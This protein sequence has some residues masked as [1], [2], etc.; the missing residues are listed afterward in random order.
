MKKTTIF[1]IFYCC[2]C[3]IFCSVFALYSYELSEVGKVAAQSVKMRVCLDAGHGGIDGGVVGSSGVTEAEINLQITLRL[4]ALLEENGIEVF[5]TR[6]DSNAFSPFKKEDMRKRSAIINDCSPNAVI[7][8]HC[9]A[10]RSAPSRRGAQVFYDDTGRGKSF[11]ENMQKVINDDFNINY[12]GKKYSALGGD[13]YLTKC[14]TVPSII[15]ECGFLSNKQDE[16]LLQTPDY[17]AKLCD[18][19]LKCLKEYKSN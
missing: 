7:S 4:G 9:N 15:I 13:Y 10:Y 12:S 16:Q 19:I 1:N 2:I 8:I 17:Q 11:A 3:L 6:K 18:S 5:Y 14:C